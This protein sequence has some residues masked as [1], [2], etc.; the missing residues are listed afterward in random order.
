MTTSSC[1]L[2]SV[3]TW[4]HLDTSCVRSDFYSSH[5]QMDVVMQPLRACFSSSAVSIVS[6][7]VQDV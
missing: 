4:L 6:F 7:V 5:L 3:K 1:T 2:H